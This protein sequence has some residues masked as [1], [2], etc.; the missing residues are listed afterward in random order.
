MI[1]IDGETF[2]VRDQ[3]LVGR[4]SAETNIVLDNPLVS[5]KHALF[6]F[7]GPRL[8]ITDLGSTNGT[9]INSKL[10][11]SGIPMSVTYEDK[12]EFADS[13]FSL[14]LTHG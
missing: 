1:G 2:A 7:H 5:R 6:R 8:E 12:I 4:N 14:Q 13:E 9:K 11:A 3:Y 10:I